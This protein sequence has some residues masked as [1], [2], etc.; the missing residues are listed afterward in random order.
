MVRPVIPLRDDNPTSVVPW[1]LYVL[2]AVNVAVFLFEVSL[3]ENQLQQFVSTYGF[4]PERAMDVFR[5]EAGLPA[6]LLVPAFTSMFLHGGVAHL[7]GNMWFL[8]IFGDNVE[9]RLGHFRFLAFYLVCGLAATALH[10]AVG[11]HSTVPTLGASGA[12]A[13]V[14]GAYAVCWP[15]ARILTLVPV[16][17]FLH[18]V[19]LPALL[20]LGMWF[21]IQLLYGSISLG[22]HFSIAYWAHIGGF[23]A[24]LALIKLWPAQRED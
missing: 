14:L 6:G 12:I 24:G 15:R 20:V 3:S 1:M 7:L 18:L 21:L 16:L 19:E 4:V 9:N 5:G 13:G 11:P 8:H 17:Y 2:I 22:V 10:Y 23:V